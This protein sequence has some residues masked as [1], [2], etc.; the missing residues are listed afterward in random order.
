MS[1]K[2][3]RVKANQQKKKFAKA[4]RKRDEMKKRNIQR[5]RRAQAEGFT[6]REIAHFRK[7]VADNPNLAADPEIQAAF[8]NAKFKPITKE[9]GTVELQMED[10]EA[11]E[12]FKKV[13]GGV[14]PVVKLKAKKEETSEECS[15]K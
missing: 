8:A 10:G 2:S 14:V 1:N 5:N 9:D 7:L 3:N 13:N 12:A 4:V 15:S 6:A 11:A